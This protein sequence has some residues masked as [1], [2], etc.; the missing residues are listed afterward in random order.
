MR[1]PLA[2]SLA[3]GLLA[4]AA[5]AGCSD[6]QGTDG[7]QYVGGDGIVIIPPEDRADPVE[8]SGPAVDGGEL[9]L[10]DYRGKV[11]VVNVWWSGCGPCR[12]EM[13]LL[14][15]VV[16]EVG[17]TRCCSA[18]TSGTR[19]GTTA[20][21]FMRGTEVQF[22][23]FYDPGGEVL[24]AFPAI[25]PRALPSTAVLDRRGRLAALVTGEVTSVVTLRD[26][27]EDVAAEPV[28]EP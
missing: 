28:T 17:S 16:E 18:S 21:A 9:D 22:A 11:V 15:D 3:A 10:A 1:R 4:L 27:V 7:K 26:V 24:L 6:L 12:Q 20:Q 8:A 2:A 19:A 14:E 25:S 23:S 13:P 5:L